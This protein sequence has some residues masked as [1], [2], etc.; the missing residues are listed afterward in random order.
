MWGLV[1]RGSELSSQDL[2][3]STP[4]GH[5]TGMMQVLTSVAR[6]EAPAGPGPDPGT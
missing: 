2:A 6:G 5:V 3:F 1:D 4:L